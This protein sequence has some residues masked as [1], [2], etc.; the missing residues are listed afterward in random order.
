M[1]KKNNRLTVETLKHDKAARKNIPTY[2]PFGNGTYGTCDQSQTG[3]KQDK[4]DI[5]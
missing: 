3:H 1:A 4:R 2:A 5:I